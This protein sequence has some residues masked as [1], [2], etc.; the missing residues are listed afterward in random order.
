MCFGANPCP[1]DLWGGAERDHHSFRKGRALR[2][3]APPHEFEI[4]PPILLSCLLELGRGL[5]ACQGLGEPQEW[6]ERQVGMRLEGRNWGEPERIR[7][8]PWGETGRARRKA[9]Q[10]EHLW[11]ET[12]R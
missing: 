4:C 11:K 8:G 5:Q 6:A 9:K 12:G 1:E 7:A 2:R 10:K 3:E